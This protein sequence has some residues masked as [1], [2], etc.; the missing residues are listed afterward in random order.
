MDGRPEAS[1]FIFSNVTPA[2]AIEWPPKAAQAAEDPA[3]AAADAKLILE[4]IYLQN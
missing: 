4:M 2:V 3:M 1:P